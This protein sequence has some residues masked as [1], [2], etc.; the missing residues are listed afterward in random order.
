MLGSEDENGSIWLFW[1]IWLLIVL[2]CCFIGC[3][4]FL[5]CFLCGYGFAGMGKSRRR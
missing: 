4:P 2:C 5:I 1:W 3:L